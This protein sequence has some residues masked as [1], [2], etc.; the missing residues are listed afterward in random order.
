MKRIAG[1]VIGLLLLFTKNIYSQIDILQEINVRYEIWEDGTIES[2]YQIKLTNLVTEKYASEYTLSLSNVNPMNVKYIENGVAHDAEVT[3]DGERS[4]IRIKFDEPVVGRDKTR[5]FEISLTD[6]DTS[7]KSGEVWEV[8]FPSLNSEIE[9]ISYEI[10]IPKSFN[11]LAYVSPKYD[12]VLET[13]EYNIYYFDQKIS[14]PISFA[15][16]EFQV[17]SFQLTSHLENP[18]NRKSEVDIAIPPDT[19]FQRVVYKKITPEPLRVS[20]DD[21]GNYL[22]RFELLPRGRVDVVVEGSVQIYPSARGVIKDL[23]DKR[24]YLRPTDFWQVTDPAILKTASELKDIAHI[25]NFVVDTLSYDYERVKPNIKRKGAVEALKDPDNSICMEF[26][27]LFIALARAKGI[28]AREIN[29]YA[30]TENQKLQPLSL[31]ADVLHSWPEY[32]DEARQLWVPVDPTWE[33]TT[34][35]EDFFSKLDLRHFVFVIH[36]TNA[37]E[38]YPPGSYKLGANPQKDIYVSFG[39]LPVERNVQLDLTINKKTG[40]F[41][42]NREYEVIIRNNGNLSSFNTQY[43]VNFDNEEKVTETINVIPPFGETKMSV[44]VPFGFTG[45]KAPSKIKFSVGDEEIT[46]TTNKELVMVV[47]ATLSLA[48][49]F[50]ASLLAFKFIKRK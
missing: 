37:T 29:G 15:F 43:N 2:N 34:G 30:Y 28:P 5:E 22:A 41:F 33:N 31:V 26:T 32:W 8:G 35:G 14:S 3:K 39:D 25:Y 18:V 27:D 46:V 23:S 24:N 4:N 7:V 20:V 9:N 44:K 16:G 42:G 19:E 12:R 45:M 1:I 40:L 48:I 17:F 10:Y 21:D 6:N 49:I 50:G 47:F 13:S 38:P 36:G 11:N